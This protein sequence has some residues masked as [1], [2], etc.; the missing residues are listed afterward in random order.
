MRS[1]GSYEWD[2]FMM[3]PLGEYTYMLRSGFLGTG[4]QSWDATSTHMMS[5]PVRLTLK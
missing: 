2:Q 3:S 1:R 5:P 4:S